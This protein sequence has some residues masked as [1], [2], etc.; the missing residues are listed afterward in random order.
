MVEGQLGGCLSEDVQTTVAQVL[1]WDA[2]DTLPGV[3]Y[4]A[5]CTIV[6]NVAILTSLAVGGSTSSAA[7]TWAS[8]F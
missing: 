6:S 5:A 4:Y 1:G 2:S 8:G 3:R 7:V